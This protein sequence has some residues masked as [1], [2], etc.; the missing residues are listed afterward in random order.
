MACL[1]LKVGKLDSCMDICDRI[2]SVDAFNEK[3]FEIKGDLHK[4]VEQLDQAFLYYKR[5]IEF[6]PDSHSA[7]SSVADILRRNGKLKE[8]IDHY[9]KALSVRI[10]LADTFSKLCSA[11]LSCCDWEQQEDCYNHLF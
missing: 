3:A 6:N 11:K 9:K 5:A 4:C 2:L 1:D 10:D 8:A 7:N